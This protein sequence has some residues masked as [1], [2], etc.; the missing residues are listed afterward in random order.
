MSIATGLFGALGSTSQSGS[1]SSGQITEDA[2]ESEILL[3]KE[4]DTCNVCNEPHPSELETFG[5]KNLIQEVEEN[6]EKEEFLLSTDLQKLDNFRQFDMVSDCSDH[7][8]LGA[9]KGLAFS[10]VR[11]RAQLSLQTHRLTLPNGLNNPFFF[12]FPFFPTGKKIL[13]EEGSA[14]VE[15][16][17]EKPPWL[18][19]F[20]F[21]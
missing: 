21:I 7:H 20:P 10:Q 5:N 2:N 19:L 8:F 14:R 6:Q 4:V 3:Q 13:G 17:R 1:L 9:S 11:N 15:H 12:T 18:A 16:S